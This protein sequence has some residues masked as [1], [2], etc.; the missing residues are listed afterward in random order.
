METWN[1]RRVLDFLMAHARRRITL[2]QR[3]ATLRLTGKLT[4]V[5]DRNACS[6]DL[7]EADLD[8]G[9]PGLQ[10][11]LTVH[12]NSVLV[13]VSGDAGATSLYFPVSIPYPELVLESADT[14]QPSSEADASRPLKRL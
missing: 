12:E 5:G 8:L 4:E 7:V 9:I 10:C 6:M 14:A 13:H 1:S 2:R 3:G 11:A